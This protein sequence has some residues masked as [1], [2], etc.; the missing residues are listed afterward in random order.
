MD[1]TL[2]ARLTLSVASASFESLP[3]RVLLACMNAPLP[4]QYIGPNQRG[5]YARF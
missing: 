4:W 2:T 1:F 5:E 3:E